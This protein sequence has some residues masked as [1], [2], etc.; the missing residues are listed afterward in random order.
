MEANNMSNE[1][2]N[3]AE[4]VVDDRPYD[5][6]FFGGK[7]PEMGARRP[8]G[9]VELDEFGNEINS[10]LQAQESTDDVMDSPEFKQLFGDRAASIKG[11]FTVTIGSLGNTGVPSGI[12][13][14]SPVNLKCLK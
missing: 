9:I 2:D 11:A 14:T 12:A 10:R 6:S 13:Y 1:F 3:P 5:Q 8:N 7:P 4:S